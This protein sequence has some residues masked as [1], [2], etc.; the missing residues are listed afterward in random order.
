L[1]LERDGLQ[2]DSGML[3]QRMPT[4]FVCEFFMRVDPYKDSE[5]LEAMSTFGNHW[6]IFVKISFCIWLQALSLRNSPI[7][8]KELIAQIPGWEVK[9]KAVCMLKRTEVVAG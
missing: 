5:L 8:K 9:S 7:F 3:E 4:N 2:R 1:Q 6:G